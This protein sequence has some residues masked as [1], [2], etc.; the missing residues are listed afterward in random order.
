MRT[1]SP[2]SSGWAV[3]ATDSGGSILGAFSSSASGRSPASAVDQV[4]V[5]RLALDAFGVIRPAARVHRDDCRYGYRVLHTVAVELGVGLERDGRTMVSGSRFEVHTGARVEFPLTPAG[6][7]SELRLRLA[8]RRAI[9]LYTPEVAVAP[10]S[11]QAT[12]V[13]DSTELYAALAVVF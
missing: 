4:P 3:S 5:D 1:S 10:G 7:P 11:A 9:G 13:G 2:P 6:L 12:A 8:M